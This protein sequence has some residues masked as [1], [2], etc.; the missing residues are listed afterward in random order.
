[1]S[2]QTYPV[3]DYGLLLYDEDVEA[4]EMEDELQHYTG[5]EGEF[6]PFEDGREPISF[7][8]E[9]FYFIPLN[10]APSL[11]SQ[12]YADVEEAKAEMLSYLSKH[13]ELPFDV[14]DRLGELNGTIFG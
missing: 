1:M 13:K 14:D 4:L 6:E 7:C 5:F 11:F 9:D 2:M 12:A 3:K 8:E 10:K